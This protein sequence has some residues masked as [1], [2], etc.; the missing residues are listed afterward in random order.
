MQ[1]KD[2]HESYCECH[3]EYMS[4]KTTDQTREPLNPPAQFLVDY[5][6]LLPKGKALDVAAG[7]GR[8][9]LYLAE[10]GF[11]VHAIDRDAAALQTLRSFAEERKLQHVTTELVDLESGPV[12]DTVFPSNTYDVVLVFLYLF[13][14]LIPLFIQTLKPGGMLVYETFTVENHL[15]NQHPRHREFCFEPNELRELVSDLHI[16]HYDEGE[17]PRP[18]GQSGIF[19]VRLLAQKKAT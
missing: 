14:P 9:A 19:T 10:H 2:L 18:D 5:I 17:R 4:T 1:L 6:H 16:V 11:S 8:N 7:R 15:R 3:R 13:R 12:S